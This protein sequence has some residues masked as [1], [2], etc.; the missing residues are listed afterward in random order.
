MGAIFML[1]GAKVEVQCKIV[2][3]ANAP[4]IIKKDSFHETGLRFNKHGEHKQ[5]LERLEQKETN[6]AGYVGCL[7]N[8]YV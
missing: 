4:V 6:L 8:V 3:N 7:P 5:H 2:T 1:D